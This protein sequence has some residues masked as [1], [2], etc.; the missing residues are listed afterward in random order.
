MIDT[1]QLIFPQDLVLQ[2][3]LE[4]L[5]HRHYPGHFWCVDVNIRQGMINVKNL[6]LSGTMGFRLKL[7]GIFTASQVEH[8]VMMAGGELLE[9]YKLARGAFDVSRWCALPT[10]RRGNFIADR[11]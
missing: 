5:L 9:R 2:K 3:D 7:Q 10:D 4:L 1:E 6:F 11:G 8:D